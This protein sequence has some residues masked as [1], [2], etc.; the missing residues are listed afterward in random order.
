MVNIQL[1][2]SAI[3]SFPSKL[4]QNSTDLYICWHQ[5]RYSRRTGDGIRSARW[6]GVP[7]KKKGGVEKERL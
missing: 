1:R 5:F 7:V 3:A 4:S 6:V 2:F